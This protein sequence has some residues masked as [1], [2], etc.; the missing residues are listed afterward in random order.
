MQAD[1]SADGRWTGVNME[2]TLRE[3]LAERGQRVL[4][5]TNGV[6]QVVGSLGDPDRLLEVVK[7]GAWNDYTVVA[8]G[9][10]VKLAINGMPMCELD[11]RDSK[12]LTRGWLAL[13]VH[14]GPPMHVQ[15]K[16]VYLRRR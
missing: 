8:K 7:P 5:A 11:D 16:D 3:V 14:T 10:L 12:R 15:F 6:K 9:G 4:V 2:Y 13:Q 1:F